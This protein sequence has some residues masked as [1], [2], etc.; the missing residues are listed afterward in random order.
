MNPTETCCRSE[1]RDENCLRSWIREPLPKELLIE[2]WNARVGWSLDR[3]RTQAAWCIKLVTGHQQVSNDK[4]R[5]EKKEKNKNKKV[6]KQEKMCEMLLRDLL[7]R[8]A[9]KGRCRTQLKNKALTGPLRQ[10]FKT[11]ANQPSFRKKF[12]ADQIRS[13]KAVTD[14]LPLCKARQWVAEEVLT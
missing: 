14:K 9:K 8:P 1:C 11:K 5:V 6:K 10:A 7:R 4:I 12:G 3:C 13:A 2:A